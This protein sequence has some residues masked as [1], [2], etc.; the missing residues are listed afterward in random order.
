MFYKVIEVSLEARIRY[1]TPQTYPVYRGILPTHSLQNIDYLPDITIW[2]VLLC[3][4][5]PKSSG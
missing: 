2:Q 1:L 4:N 3:L 5:F